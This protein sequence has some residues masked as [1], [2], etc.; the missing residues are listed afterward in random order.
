MVQTYRL[1]LLAGLFLFILLM[2]IGIASAHRL[3]GKFRHTTGQWL[4]LGYTRSGDYWYQAERA[5][6]S[7]HNTPTRLVVYKTTYANSK[8]DFYTVTNSGTWWGLAVHHPCP[9]GGSNCVYSWADLYMNKRTLANQSTATRQKVAAHELG[10]GI[11]LAHTTSIFY[12]SIMKQGYLSYNT[13]QTH[14]VTD[15]NGIYR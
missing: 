11:G 15:T 3:G 10:H 1:K 7:W 13:P 14:D 8:V 4:Y 6:V 5:A 12:R 2:P 9:G